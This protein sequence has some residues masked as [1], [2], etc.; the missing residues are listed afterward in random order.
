MCGIFGFSGRNYP[1]KEIMREIAYLAGTRGC[2]SN[3]VAWLTPDGAIHTKKR[4]G[5]I[6]PDT[7]FEGATSKAIIGHCRL[8][9]SGPPTLANA[10]PLASPSMAVA[11]NGTIRNYAELAQAYK[12]QLHTQCDSELLLRIDPE[13]L[14]G[15][16]SNDPYAYL[17]IANGQ[18]SARRRDMPLYELKTADGTYWC[19]RKFR[20]ATLITNQKQ[21][22][23]E[24]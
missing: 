12:G 24:K 20:E 9:T 13:T 15:R 6:D 2:H 22:S 11:H 14:F 10:Q 5:K 1:D 8:S 4:L 3:G 19:S 18:I 21:N 7:I 23:N 17:V 16:L